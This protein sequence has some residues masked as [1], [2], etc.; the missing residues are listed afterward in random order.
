MGSEWRVDNFPH[1]PD[2]RMLIMWPCRRREDNAKPYNLLPVKVD[3]RVWVMGPNGH[4][5]SFGID[6]LAFDPNHLGLWKRS[7]V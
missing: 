2:G 7:A 6:E 4:L 5:Q 1:P 3:E